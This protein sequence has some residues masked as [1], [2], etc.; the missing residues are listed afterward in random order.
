MDLSLSDNITGI[1]R[2]MPG[3]SSRMCKVRLELDECGT[4]S[5]NTIKHYRGII[6]QRTQT[7]IEKG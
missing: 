3:F 4:S 5:A 6:H 7:E 2:K 1:A